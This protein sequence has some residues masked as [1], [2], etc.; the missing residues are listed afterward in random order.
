M[1][2]YRLVP[3]KATAKVQRLNFQWF[4][5]KFAHSLEQCEDESRYNELQFKVLS[6]IIMTF[7]FAKTNCYILFNLKF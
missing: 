4:N 6:R 5:R 7:D 2:F 3:H 1:Q